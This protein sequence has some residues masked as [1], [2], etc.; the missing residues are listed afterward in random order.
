MIAE[1]SGMAPDELIG[2]IGDLHLY[3]EHA[4]SALEQF[5][6]LGQ[7]DY[8]K[9]H[10]GGVHETVDDFNADDFSVTNYHPDGVIKAKLLVGN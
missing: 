7:E 6:R 4:E 3:E 9:L 5:A 10:I 1:L 2:S 8:P